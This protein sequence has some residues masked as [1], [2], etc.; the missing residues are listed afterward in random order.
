MIKTKD[1]HDRFL[2]LAGLMVV[3][4]IYGGRVDGDWSRSKDALGERII[5][6]AVRSRRGG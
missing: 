1:D 4:E 3:V 2:F 5:G 6:L